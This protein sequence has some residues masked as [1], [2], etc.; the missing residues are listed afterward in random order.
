MI[1]AAHSI[2]AIN[3]RCNKPP[4][5]VWG[6]VTMGDMTVRSFHFLLLTI[7]TLA[8]GSILLSVQASWL[9]ASALLSAAPLLVLW[10]RVRM[11]THTIPLVALCT[12]LGT[13]MIELF[14][15]KTGIWFEVSATGTQFAGVPVSAYLFSV[16]HILYLIIV[17]EYFFDDGRNTGRSPFS[18]SMI[19]YAGLGYTAVAGYLYVYP[20]LFIAHPFLALVVALCVIFSILITVRHPVG[21]GRLVTR[22]IRFTF[23]MLPISLAYECIMVANNIRFFANPEQYLY[24]FSV[25]QFSIPIEEVFLI[26]LIPF[27]V[28]VLYELY[29]DDAR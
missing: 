17:Y 25:A 9:V 13:G 29:F 3:G 4:D 5:F 12:I 28:A 23:V 19:V 1:Y 20:D 10:H 2:E 8:V 21:Y 22:A 11:S 6:F 7:Y 15:Y 27:G 26:L 18:Q 16:L 14:A 24:S